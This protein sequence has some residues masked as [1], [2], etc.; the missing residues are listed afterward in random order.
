MVAV[1]MFEFNGMR[2]QPLRRALAI[3]L[4]FGIV[5]IKIKT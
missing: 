5:G 3:N 1:V 4:Y 2:C